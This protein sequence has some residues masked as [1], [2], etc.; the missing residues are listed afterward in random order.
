MPKHESAMLD[1]LNA[2]ANYPNIQM[3]TEEKK[4]EKND[5]RRKKTT[6]GTPHESTAFMNF[7]SAATDTLYLDPKRL[8][9]TYK[10]E[11]S[12]TIDKQR[13]ELSGDEAGD[14]TR[15]EFKQFGYDVYNSKS[16]GGASEDITHNKIEHEVDDKHNAA[17]NRDRSDKV[18][19]VK[20][21][22]LDIERD[23]KKTK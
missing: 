17:K 12:H 21:D 9:P 15:N 10:A 19:K 20:Q 23:D 11:V 22:N 4:K 14:K 2:S 7:G 1:S 18:L 5:R 6:K 16:G 3:L 13:N 8:L